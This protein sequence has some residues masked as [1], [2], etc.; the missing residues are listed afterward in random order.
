MSEPKQNESNF[1]PF[2]GIGLCF[3]GGGYR[4]T[5][6]A[7]GVISYLNR[8]EYEGNPLLNRARA[9]SSVS[10]G[11]LLAV[12][13][14]KA[15]QSPDFN[16]HSFYRDFYHQFT[17]ENDT[18]LGD[19]VDKLENQNVW[20]KF[21]HK[22]QSI[23]NAFALTYSEMDIFKGAFDNYRNESDTE[24]KD[25]C[26]NSTE[27]SFG[28]PFRF[29]N[30]GVFGNSPL[31]SANSE[32]LKHEVQLGDIVASSSC[33]PLGFE[34]LI[35]PDDYFANQNTDTYKAL[36]KEEYF[37]EGIGV[38][39][40]GI[41]DNQGIESMINITKRRANKDR[42]NL[43][44]VN[45]VASYK[46]VPWVPFN[47]P[48]E[49]RKS[50]KTTLRNVLG[51]LK[52]KWWYVALAVLGVL[53]MFL[54]TQNVFGKADYPWVFMVGGILLG[55][56]TVLMVIGGILSSIRRNTETW[57]KDLIRS[58]APEVLLNDVISFQNLEVGLLQRMLTE[59][60]TSGAKMINDV[61][62]KQ[63]RRLNYNMLYNEEGLEDK[64]I[65]STVYQLNGEETPYGNNSFNKDIEPT[66]STSLKKTALIA[67]QTPTTLWWDEEDVKVNRMDC[68][69][70]CGQ[71]TTCYNLLDYV[72][73]LR[74]KGHDSEALKA[75]EM[76]L[77]EDW[78]QLNNNPMTWVKP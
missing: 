27:F 2:D 5:F 24:L 33:F 3:S 70:A 45:D 34:P 41:A 19:A 71:F 39:D 72:L 22:K 47:S 75:L 56:G 35:F 64:R 73:G 31:K 43:I 18:L 54:N 55:M 52:I 53:M 61:F 44:M 21:P 29:Q 58:K 36:K 1:I 62:L 76:A 28:L 67:S 12:A 8:I 14:S 37:K 49:R 68:L 40:G 65:T 23:I 74:A 7:L 9:V 57:L 30:N 25:V 11:T 63:I 60:L 51:Y 10:G 17:P 4:A 38:M 50:L 78:K 48:I 16:F 26:F 20:K 42:F 46:M 59:R 13:Y 15:A 6:F 77:S 66:P 69:I 32:D